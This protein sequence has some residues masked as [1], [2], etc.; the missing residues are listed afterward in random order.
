MALATVL[1][2]EADLARRVGDTR[3][4]VDALLRCYL[5][6]AHAHQHVLE[7][8]LTL[9]LFRAYK[10][11]RGTG[12]SRLDPLLAAARRAAAKD[13]AAAALEG[14]VLVARGDPK[15]AIEA[16]HRALKAS[17]GDPYVLR[18]LCTLETGEARVRDLASLFEIE[19]NDATVGFDLV[20]A[21]FQS[22]R[23]VDALQRA[24]T[25]RQRFPD[26]VLVLTELAHLLSKNGAHA[27]A[28]PILERVLRLDPRQPDHL[29]AYG[30][31]LRTMKR[32]DEAAKAYFGLVEKDGSQVAY[33]QLIEV[34][35]QRRLIPELKRAYQEALRHAPDNWELRRDYARWLASS[36]QLDESLAEWKAI[37]A[38]TKDP[39]LKDFAERE[40]KRLETQKLFNR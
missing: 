20:S 21:L 24:A 30:D 23:Q 17:P 7:G 18:R 26:N 14:D 1:R 9:D 29:I 16:F 2:R 13:P 22:Q 15:G 34:L 33:H 3:L 37:G 35:S 32:N 28:V 25:L 10:V 19:L 39:F 40:I 36:G 27:E 8:E 4:M 6:A 11:D 38:T 31:E 12:G 5:L